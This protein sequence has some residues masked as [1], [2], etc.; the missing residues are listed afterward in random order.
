MA[1]FKG[2]SYYEAHVDNAYEPETS[3]SS[4]DEDTDVPFVL[5]RSFVF[6]EI[7]HQDALQELYSK[8][9]LDGEILFGRAFFQ[10]G[11]FDEF[12]KLVFRFTMPGGTH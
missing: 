11:S 12:A 3:R 10:T 1:C 4:D 9:K 6:W 8:F 7:E 5:R 2:D